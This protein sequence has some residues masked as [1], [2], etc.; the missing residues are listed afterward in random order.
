MAVGDIND[1]CFF[2]LMNLNSSLNLFRYSIGKQ[3]VVS[4]PFLF[5]KRFI[6]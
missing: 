4:I 2:D 6:A 3:G 1:H 5:L